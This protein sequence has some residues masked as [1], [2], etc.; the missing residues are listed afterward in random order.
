MKKKI[1]VFLFVLLVSLICSCQ[2]F[3]WDAAIYVFNYT[4]SDIV[5]SG[6]INGQESDEL[7]IKDEE[8]PEHPDD[9]TYTCEIAF[10]PFD[11]SKKVVITVEGAYKTKEEY[12]FVLEPKENRKISV[13]ADMGT[14]HFIHAGPE[15]LNIWV[16]PQNPLEYTDIG[17]VKAEAV[18]QLAGVNETNQ[19]SCLPGAWYVIYETA[20]GFQHSEDE[21]VVELND[22]TQVGFWTFTDHPN[23]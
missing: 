13:E 22:G 1:Y 12:S 4:A 7:Q 3:Y 2:L 21:F 5:I 8:L 9:D 6:V 17:D 11:D 18:S 14:M 20:D 23:L 19:L 10:G 16:V 15:V